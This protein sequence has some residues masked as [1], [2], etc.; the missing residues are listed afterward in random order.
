MRLLALLTW[1]A[2]PVYIWQGLG[3]RR[4]TS[5][6]LPAQGPVMHDIK[7]KAPTISLLVL[8][9]SSAASVGIGNSENG[10]PRNWQR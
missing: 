6:M 2:F 8:G 7:G 3:V 1:F 5:R 10:L 4:R 9:D